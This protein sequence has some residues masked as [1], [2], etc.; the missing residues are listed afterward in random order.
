MQQQ[1][2]GD[3]KS[4][5]AG[6]QELK[7]GIGDIGAGVVG[8]AGGFALH[9]LHQSGKIVAGIGDAGDADAGATSQVPSG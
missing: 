9:V 5:L 7:V 6:F 4:A 8:D 1:I 2:Y 3:L